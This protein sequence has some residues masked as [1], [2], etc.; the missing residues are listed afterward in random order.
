MK[1]AMHSKVMTIANRLVAQGSSRA[2]A[3]VKAWA[4]VKLPKLETKV[5]GVTF[6]NRQLFIEQLL[7]CAPESISIRLE[8]EPGN[9]HDKNAVAVYAVVEGQ[10]SHH[11]G[12]I[13][14]VISGVIMR[15]KP[16]ISPRGI[17]WPLHLPRPLL[18][19]QRWR[20]HGGGLR[21]RPRLLR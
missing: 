15:A 17:R 7:D 2:P 4:L 5:A 11:M 19:G 3:M 9:E 13:L 16:V 21:F 20:G 12:V 6:G 8:R 14:R 18:F 10:Q 1:K